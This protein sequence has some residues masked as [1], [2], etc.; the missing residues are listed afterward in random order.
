M[1]D[2][3]ANRKAVVAGFYI[4][5][6]NIEL[7]EENIADLKEN[8]GQNPNGK[9]LILH[10]RGSVG[11]DYYTELMDMLPDELYP[12]DLESIAYVIVIDG[13]FEHTGAEYYCGTK[14]IQEYTSVT[15]YDMVSGEELLL[16]TVQG[17]LSNMMTYEGTPPAYYSAGA[18]N[19][20]NLLYDALQNIWESMNNQ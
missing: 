12:N 4:I 15:L 10:K 19:V 9:V 17:P 1:S 7:S 2:V 8:C 3:I 20:S 6:E 18:P 13:S 5:K 14:Q 16:G 11:L